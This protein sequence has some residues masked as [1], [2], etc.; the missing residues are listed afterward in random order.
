MI[1]CGKITEVRHAPEYAEN[2]RCEIAG[3]YDF[4]PERAQNTIAK[5]R[6]APTADKETFKAMRAV[7]AA[8]ESARTDKTIPVNQDE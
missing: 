5:N 6:F 2:P 1:G 8:G 4:V 7:L 3:F